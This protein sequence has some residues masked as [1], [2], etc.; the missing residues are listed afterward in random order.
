[1]WIA[2]AQFQDLSAKFVRKRLTQVFTFFSPGIQADFK[3][4]QIGRNLIGHNI[5][6]RSKES[7]ALEDKRRIAIRHDGLPKGD[8]DAETLQWP[9]GVS[10]KKETYIRSTLAV[11][12]ASITFYRHESLT[13]A[14]ALDRLVEHYRAW[15][16]NRPGGRR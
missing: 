7:V 10:G 8:D 5:S 11:D 6:S 14:Q 9:V 1:M 16:V 13:P 12:G 15:A 4:E 3:V 2:A